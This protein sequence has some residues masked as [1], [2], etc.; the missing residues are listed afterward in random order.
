MENDHER[1]R[2]VQFEIA[3]HVIHNALGFGNVGVAGGAHGFEAHAFETGDGVF[4]AE[5]VLDRKAESPAESLG[6]AAD[7]GTFFGHLDEHLAGLAVGVEA[8]G[9]IALVVADREFVRDRFA[10]GGKR[11]A[12]CGHG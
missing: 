1:L 11:S 12:K 6:H 3:S 2:E 4:D 9:E 10:S 8:D 7:G 5:A